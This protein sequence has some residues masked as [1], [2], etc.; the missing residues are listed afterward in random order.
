M[1]S[2][3]IRMTGKNHNPNEQF[4]KDSSREET[5]TREEMNEQLTEWEEEAPP[6]TVR[7]TEEARV[8]D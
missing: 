5:N 1:H 7:I 4:L 3:E 2:K 6:G 8:E